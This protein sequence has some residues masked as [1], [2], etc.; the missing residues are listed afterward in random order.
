MLIAHVVGAEK[1]GSREDASTGGE[2]RVEGWT[3]FLVKLIALRHARFSSVIII[4]PRQEQ[5]FCLY[6][7]LH[8]LRRRW[9]K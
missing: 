1:N 6:V 4:P 2:G 3:S 7:K 9:I 5:P 8:L